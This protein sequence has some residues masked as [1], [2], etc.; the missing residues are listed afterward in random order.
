MINNSIVLFA[1]YVGAA[2]APVSVYHLEHNYGTA[3]LF[4]YLSLYVILVSFL[5]L[6]LVS[7]T[8]V[9][10][11]VPLSLFPYPPAFLQIGCFLYFRFIST[12]PL[13]VPF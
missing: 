9:S 11:S 13:V 1:S 3:Q 5:M 6:I 4:R 8:V 2:E 12:F 10:C 7:L